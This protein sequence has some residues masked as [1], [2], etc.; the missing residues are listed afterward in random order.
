MEER[1]GVGE[2]EFIEYFIGAM[3]SDFSIK[4]WFCV[5]IRLIGGV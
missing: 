1:K 4:G 5:E 2:L 3:F